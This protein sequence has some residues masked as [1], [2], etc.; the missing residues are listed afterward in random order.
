MVQR[1]ISRFV[2]LKVLFTVI[3][4]L[5]LNIQLFAAEFGLN[6]EQK[7]DTVYF[8]SSAKLEFIEGKTTAIKGY[9]SCNPD[10]MTTGASGLFQVDLRTLKTGIATRDRHMRERHLQT[11]TYPYAWFKLLRVTGLP[12]QLI[13]DSVY[14]GAAKGLFYLHGYAQP[15]T[16]KITVT[17]VNEPTQSIDLQIV[18]HF[19]IHLK[20]FN[21]SRPKMLF[22][23]VADTIEVTVEF[24]G[25]SGYHNDIDSLPDWEITD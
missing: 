13:P 24:T 21:I 23:K 10:D 18:A 20:D 19:K 2:I 17:R 22:L 12:K 25:I 6:H 9:F 15:V 5:L 7:N 1:T 14:S 3:V 4:I 11:D 8:Q 16:P